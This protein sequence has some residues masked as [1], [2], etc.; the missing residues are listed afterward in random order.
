MKIFLS[1]CIFDIKLMRFLDN[2]DN[3]IYSKAFSD[4]FLKLYSQ[5]KGKFLPESFGA[6]SIDILYD[7]MKFESKSESK[8]KLE[9]ES[10][11]YI[12]LLGYSEKK[13]SL[14]LTNY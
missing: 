4:Y 6:S 9:K 8:R 10:E 14:I 2:V 5:S 12:V 13:A 3:I 1:T 7:L 11:K